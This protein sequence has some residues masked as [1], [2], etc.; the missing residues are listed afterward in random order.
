MPR[1]SA[2]E[3]LLWAAI[4]SIVFAFLFIVV[5]PDSALASWYHLWQAL[6]V[7]ASVLRWILLAAVALILYL[8]PTW[9]AILRKHR[10]LPSI[11][12]LNIG[13]GVTVIGWF[14]ALVWAV[15]RERPEAV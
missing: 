9:T 2:P 14:I 7:G 11:A 1:R 12:I 3:K 8:A 5:S 15:Y 4:I 6:T 10:N 13:L